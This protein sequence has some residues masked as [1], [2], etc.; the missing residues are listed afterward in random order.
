MGSVGD[1]VGGGLDLMTGG[2]YGSATGKG[3]M[4]GLKGAV[5]A[6]GNL[7]GGGG[8]PDMSGLNGIQQT[9]LAREAGAAQ[10]LQDV[11]E[12]KKGFGTM[13][14]NAALGKGP[15]LAQAQLQQAQDRNLAQQLAMAKSQRGVS[16]AL[17]ARMLQQNAAQSGQQL[18]GQSAVARLQEQRQQQAAFQDYLANQQQYQNN[19][20][21]TAMGGEQARA[22]ANAAERGRSDAMLGNLVGTG[23]MLFA[24]SDKNLK[25]DIKNVTKPDL[26]ESISKKQRT[27]KPQTQ[28]NRKGADEGGPTEPIKEYGALKMNQGG[29]VPDFLPANTDTRYRISD[30]RGP[31][32]DFASAL[33]RMK[34]NQPESKSFIDA[35]SAGAL[36]GM[37]RRNPA[38]PDTSSYIDAPNATQFESSPFMVAAEGGTVPGEAEVQGDSVKNDKVPAL[39][40]PGEVVVPRSVV[41]KGPEAAAKFVADEEEKQ[42]NPKSFLDA[43]QAYSYKYK[44]PKHGQGQQLSVMAQDLEKAGPVGRSMVQQTP[45]GKMVNYAKGFAGILAAQAHLNERLKDIEA[46]YGK[47]GG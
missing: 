2:L 13:L 37:F 21:N 10:S 29:T 18:A 3:W 26:A 25:R 5:D 16:P 31:G 36:A 20:L 35:K 40:S 42:F 38:A 43:L 6:A 28:P 9:A 11:A 24:A 12:Q 32:N 17:Q 23:A 4:G 22:A 19:L 34:S 27:R 30:D 39:L 8:G 44:D 15:S 46:R 47:K 7:I 14:G 33:A 41:A 1:I 45:E